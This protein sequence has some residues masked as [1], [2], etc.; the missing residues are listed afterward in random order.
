MR[1]TDKKVDNKLRLVLT[2]VCETALKEINGFQW[3]THLVNYSNFPQ[4]LKVVCV[5]DTNDHLATFIASSN[6]N[7][8]TS[9][10]E[11]KLNEIDIKLKNVAAQL[12]YD[13]EENCAKFHNGNWANRLG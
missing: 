2:D 9:L 7:L 11:S 10:I 6:K 12:L 3:L 13:T 5:F 1:K 8:F 4:S